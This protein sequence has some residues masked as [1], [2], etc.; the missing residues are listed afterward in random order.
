MWGTWWVWDAR[1]TAILIM[2]FFYLGYMAIWAAIEEP[3]KAADLSAVVCLV[4]FIF[5]LMSRYAVRFWSTLH[6]DSSL[7]VQA[8][9]RIDDVFRTPLYACMVAFCILALALLLT[10]VRTEI[11][12]RRARAL[13]LREVTA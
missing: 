10:R 3:E 9:Q 13:R 7:S 5:A 6:Q 8:G 11:R 2:F 4:G 12:V 1:L